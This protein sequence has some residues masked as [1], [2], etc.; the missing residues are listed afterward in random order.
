MTERHLAPSSTTVGAALRVVWG[1]ALAAK[2]S[3]S[4]QICCTGSAD[5]LLRWKIF[6]GRD[7]VLG[8]LFSHRLN[9]SFAGQLQRCLDQKICRTGS[10]QAAKE[11]RK[12]FIIEL[13]AFWICRSSQAKIED[14]FAGLRFVFRQSFSHR[15][16]STA[17][18]QSKTHTRRLEFNYSIK[19]DLFPNK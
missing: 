4:A 7:F 12:Y 6:C 1:A 10:T 5:T 3:G 2:I 9:S 18:E 13:W 16:N 17:V 14:Y 11:E 19:K 8:Q 15:F